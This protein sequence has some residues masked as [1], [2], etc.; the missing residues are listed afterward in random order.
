MT[1]PAAP[2][3]LAL[4][5]FQD[6]HRRRGTGDGAQ[7][8]NSDA[9]YDE[10]QRRLR[11]RDFAPHIGFLS[12]A[13]AALVG[14]LKLFTF[15]ATYVAS[16][17]ER[18]RI[19]AKRAPVFEMIVSVLVRLLDYQLWVF[20]PVCLSLVLLEA[21]VGQTA[22]KLLSAFKIVYSLKVTKE[23]ANDLGNFLMSRAGFFHTPASSSTKVSSVC[24]IVVY[25]NCLFKLRTAQE[26]VNSKSDWYQTINWMLAPLRDTHDASIRSEMVRTD[27]SWIANTSSFRPVVAALTN[28]NGLYVY[29][30]DA[31]I[32]FMGL[33]A[34]ADSDGARFCILDHPDYRPPYEHRLIYQHHV[35]TEHGTAGNEDNALVLARARDK[36]ERELAMP[37]AFVVGDQQSYAR[38]THFK[39]HQPEGREWAIPMPGDFH[40]IVH[41]LM[42]IHSLWFFPLVGFFVLIGGLSENACSGT[43][44]GK[45]DSV[46]KYN[47]YRY[48]YQLVIVTLVTYL[49]EAVPP[50][51][52]NNYNEL[53]R[54]ASVNAGSVVL[55]RFLFEFGLPWLSLR[56][57]IRANDS[58]K[59]D[60]SWQLALPLFRATGKHLYA[61]LSMDTTYVLFAMLP[62][63]RALWHENRTVAG[64][65]DGRNIAWDQAMEGM[66]GAVKPAL[67]DG[68]K[69]HDI[70]PFITRLNG[71]RYVGKDLRRVLGI[72]DT[73]DEDSRATSGRDV[74]AL[75]EALREAL[76]PGQFFHA[77]PTNPFW[78]TPPEAATATRSASRPAGPSRTPWVKVEAAREDLGDFVWSH[79]QNTNFVMHHEPRLNSV[80]V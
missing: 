59:I 58:E 12:M 69:R 2:A 49:Q 40:F 76:P 74:A 71:V 45:W 3:T 8:R 66:N 31:W 53:L 13:N 70:D 5:R 20:L 75:L 62:S 77:S 38:L 27:G 1:E 78:T 24:C 16:F 25:D 9:A 73:V 63:L 7:A 14:F 55:L 21:R 11:E 67:F 57:A 79:L 52:L 56:Q 28:F 46:E 15:S 32:H 64:S 51:L 18:A 47:D 50:P 41:F 26:H 10:I 30:H 35:P 34:S 80:P 22:F 61:T 65:H 19:D 42:G 37:F 23:I 4:D 39:R 60:L 43:P 54:R 29:C 36:V 72:E 17:S 48:L 68:A 6:A 33:A 44:L